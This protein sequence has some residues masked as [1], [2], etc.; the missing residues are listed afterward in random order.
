MYIKKISGIRYRMK[1]N[2]DKVKC[3]AKNKDCEKIGRYL[4]V[5]L[6]KYNIE[7]NF[8]FKL[9]AFNLIFN[10]SQSKL[11]SF[12]FVDLTFVCNFEKLFPIL[13]VYP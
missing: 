3:K 2:I 5:G 11:S 4:I 13:F 10:K 9:I 7:Q 1:H 6:E 12:A 8:S